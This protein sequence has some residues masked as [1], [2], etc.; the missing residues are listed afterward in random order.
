MGKQL[1]YMR[2]QNFAFCPDVVVLN[3]LLN[4]MIMM[5]R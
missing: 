3:D 5:K 2:E 1:V 4:I